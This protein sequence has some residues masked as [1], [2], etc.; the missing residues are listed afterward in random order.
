MGET[1]R[2]DMQ[3]VMEWLQQNPS[4]AS[5]VER[6]EGFFSIVNWLINGIFDMFLHG[7]YSGL[8][9]SLSFY[10]TLWVTRSLYTGVAIL[11]RSKQSM[12]KELERDM[13]RFGWS[14]ALWSCV[15]VHLW[16]DRLL[17]PF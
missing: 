12:P 14:V 13:L 10:L 15:T 6:I 3:G 1:V 5:L 7:V 16:Q 17:G 2:I 11:S 9:F 8:A 4:L